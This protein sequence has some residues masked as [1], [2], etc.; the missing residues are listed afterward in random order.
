MTNP[1]WRWVGLR[2]GRRVYRHEII[3]THRDGT[4]LTVTVE[5]RHAEYVAQFSNLIRKQYAPSPQQQAAAEKKPDVWEQFK[6][7][8]AKEKHD[9][10]I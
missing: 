10:K 2:E 9:P 8:L 7:F 4:K 3:I 6:D 1:F 5:G